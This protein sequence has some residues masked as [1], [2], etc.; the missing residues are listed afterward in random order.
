MFT[1]KNKN[2][3]LDIATANSRTQAVWFNNKVSWPDLVSKLSRTVRTH[4]KFS[5]YMSMEKAR[6]DEIKDVGGF[7]GG[8][9]NKGVRSKSTIQHR[10]ILTLDADDVKG[11]FWGAFTM[12]YGEAAVVYSTHKHT[13][14]APRLRLVMP[15]SRPVK[16]EEYEAVARKVAASI[17]ID[18]FDP[19]TF[20]PERLMYWPSTA[21]DGEWL[22][23]HQEGAF[24]DVDSVLAS[25]TDWTDM[26][27]WPR[28]DKDK[29][30]V[31]REGAKLGDPIEKTGVVGAFCRAYNIHEAI[32]EF[33]PDVYEKG[34]SDDRYTYVEG[35]GSNGAVVYNDGMFIYS[36]HATDPASMQA[37]NAFD[38]VRIHKFGNLDTEKDRGKTVTALPSYEA[39]CAWAV[40]NPEVVEELDEMRAFRAQE[41][42][43]AAVEPV[44]EKDENEV[45]KEIETD[46]ATLLGLK[47][48]AEALDSEDSIDETNWRSVLERK[49]NGELKDTISNLRIILNY[50][51]ELSGGIALNEFENFIYVVG[52]LPW[53]KNFTKPRRWTDADDSGLRYYIE[54]RY[55]IYHVG[56]TTDAMVLA[57]VRNKYHPVRDYLDGLTWDGVHRLDTLLVKYLGAEDTP[58]TRAVTRKAF[59]AAVARIYRP[60]CK[61]DY[62]LTLAG[63]EGIKKSGLLTEMGGAWF[64]DSFHTVT[65]KD[66]YEQLQGSWILEIAELS[67]FN[68]A[69]TNAIKAFVTKR[70]D[71]YRAAYGKHVQDWPRQSVFFATTNEPTFLKGH[72]GNRRFWPVAVSKRYE[73]DVALVNDIDSPREVI[74]GLP[75][76][77]LWAEAK[78]WYKEGE[79][80]YLQ[81]RNVEEAAKVV[82]NKYSEIDDRVGLVAKFLDTILP[83]NWDSMGKEERRS[84][85]NDRDEIKVKGTVFR[86]EVC[87][88]EIWSEALG[89]RVEDFNTAKGR[90]LRALMNM[91]VG[92][93]YVGEQKSFPLYGRQRYFERID[94]KETVEQ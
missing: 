27:S 37:C 52:K 79:P 46:I 18:W 78:H 1:I 12:F 4:E 36:N 19:T 21:S 10:Q 17:D 68:K 8:F 26:S 51:K 32:A 20:Q 49:K 72:T 25:Y 69:E 93:Q 54:N 55:G 90:E 22:F 60:G 71:K 39:M 5:A 70:T 43:L 13:S 14:Q 33:L 24:L 35:S 88:I 15:L 38:I 80:L 59:A 62:V 41:R 28:A 82:Q 73:P 67:A 53:I 84:Y 45:E 77:Q 65:G 30:R 47:E 94:K 89:M 56:K 91:V 63:P 42:E 61:F 66:A 81:D 9:L 34:S 7:V 23:E 50:D 40:T 2:M 58:Y 87:L 16:P 44:V 31:K 64:S 85:L 74:V 3:L 48:Q 76:D 86:N 83:E 6:Q 75:V 11:D 57:A 29:L 92:W